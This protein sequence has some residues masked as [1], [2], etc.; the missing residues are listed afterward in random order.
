MPAPPKIPWQITGNHWVSVPCIHPSDGAIHALGVVVRRL[1]GSVEFAGGPGFIDGRAPALLQL[2]LEVDGSSVDLAS[3]QVAWQRIFE[4]LPTFNASAGDVTIRGTIFAPH[5]RGNEM[6]SVVYAL[7]FEN[8]SDRPVAVRL[9]PN[10]TLGI[11]QHRV[12][13]AR[14]LADAHSYSIGDGVVTLSGTSASE[15][16]ALAIGLEGGKAS[17]QL[18]NDGLVTWSIA[19]E[20][21]VPPKQDIKLAIYLAVAPERDGAA[22]AL[23]AVQLRGWQASA[24]ATHSALAALEQSTGVS[25][26]DR[27]VNRHLIFAYFYSIV[28][29]IDDA[30]IYIVRSRSPWNSYGLTLREWDALMW[31]V[32]AVQ[33][34]DPDLARELIMRMC[35]IHGYAPGKGVNYLDGV[36]F[37]LGF[38]LDGA[39][40]YVIAVDRYIGQ[41]GDDRLVEEHIIADT[42]YASY[43][44]ISLRRD[45]QKSLYSTEVTASGAVSLPYTLHAN[46]AVA[47]ALDIFKQTLDEK[48]AEKVETGD[49]VRAAIKRHFVIQAEGESQNSFATAI[50]LNGDVVLADDTVSSAYLVPMYEL[51]SRTDSTYRRTMKRF[52]PVSRNSVAEECAR[53]LSGDTAGALDWLRRA[54]M[55]NGVAA[56]TVDADGNAIENGGDAALSGL[57]AY[58]VWF[59]VSVLGVRL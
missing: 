2:G 48:T 32:P 25:A 1:R 6:P 16:I 55:D 54:T 28:R 21:V 41:T 8:R 51:V 20:V 34:A 44:D 53:L 11:R 36:P 17:A 57:V 7:A 13:T 38:S 31:V 40:A 47:Y 3:S 45:E 29:A 59:A 10:G 58:S 37:Q 14:P 22:A 42:L 23:A 46:A 12:R 49:I 30:Q 56:E 50:D 33:L 15:G 26:A 27:L 52:A 4:W 43:E 39:A 5:G 35:E 19:R 24:T 9:T 18:N